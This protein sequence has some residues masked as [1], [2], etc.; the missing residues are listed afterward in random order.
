MQAKKTAS[1]QSSPQRIVPTNTALSAAKSAAIRARRR[2]Q[3]R[4]RFVEREYLGDQDPPLARMLR[5]GRGGQVRLKLYLSYLWMQTD[6]FGVSLGYPARAWAA[7]L[8][9]RDP[10]SAGARRIT[11][12][13]AW[14]EENGFIAVA[15]RPGLGNLITLLDDGG[16]GQPYVVP[17][18]AANRERQEQGKSLAHRYIQLPATFWTEG[19]IAI[20]SGAAVAMLLALL[21][22]KGGGEGTGLW[23][24]PGD[25]ERRF[26]L[27]EDTRGKGLRE[28][29]E[30]GIVTTR[31]R[32]V[33]PTDFD[34]LRMRNVHDLNLERLDE[35]A[36]IVRTLQSGK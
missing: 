22:E 35:P 13:Q 17:G 36:S 28:L 5:G 25:A 6:D 10:G 1:K 30:A 15:S 29:A 18:S 2:A 9:L 24:S 21:C 12:A 32:P 4:Y 7:M 8:G 16:T 26:G 3:V 23:F 14:L 31:R 19:H 27:S 33:N 34:I 11:D 20:L